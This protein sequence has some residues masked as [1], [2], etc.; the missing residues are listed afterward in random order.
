M[1]GHFEK[2]GSAFLTLD[3]AH[4]ELRNWIKD[5]SIP[6]KLLSKPDLERYLSKN[7]TKCVNFNHQKGF[8]GYRLKSICP[9]EEEDF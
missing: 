9:A 1:E 4:V 5:D 7:L 2:K 8:K 6:I 3:E